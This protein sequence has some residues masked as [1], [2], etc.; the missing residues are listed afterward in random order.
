MSWG[1]LRTKLL[2]WRLQSPAAGGCAWK[3]LLLFNFM[4]LCGTAWLLSM[5]YHVEGLQ[6]TLCALCSCCQ[7]HVSNCYARSA[8]RW[9][10]A[11][12]SGFLPACCAQGEQ[13]ALASP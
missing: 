10:C 1:G 9:L 12:Q 4:F 11:P 7:L 2:G 3:G 13:L 8:W 5:H 6:L